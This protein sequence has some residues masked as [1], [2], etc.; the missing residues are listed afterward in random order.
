[1][2]C[3]SVNLTVGGAWSLVR[4]VGL[5]ES[6]ITQ[7]TS[8]SAPVWRI[9]LTGVIEGEYLHPEAPPF[10]DWDPRLNE[11]RC[12]PGQQRLPH[13]LLIAGASRPSAACP[14]HLN[15]PIFLSKPLELSLSKCFNRAKGKASKTS[16]IECLAISNLKEGFAFTYISRRF[17]LSGRGMAE[18]AGSWSCYI[19]DRKQR[20]KNA[21]SQLTSSFL[22]R[23]SCLTD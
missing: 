3:L 4:V 1:M 5:V 10:P 19:L 14:H 16:A 20:R 11:W 13:C 23:G 15:F 22:L 12:G 6:C 17:E 21:N 18:E 2:V 7:E 8:P 9:V